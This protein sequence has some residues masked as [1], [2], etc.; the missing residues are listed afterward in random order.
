[1]KLEF[2]SLKEL[3]EFYE[4]LNNQE[5]IIDK[6]TINEQS[7]DLYE[8]LFAKYKEL[9]FKK[10][11]ISFIG[12]KEKPVLEVLNSCSS[13]DKNIRRLLFNYCR[14]LLTDETR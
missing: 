1:M 6:E 13:T 8:F 11:K 7:D 10:H 14:T 12:E 2:E 5:I 9:D 3:K 4:S